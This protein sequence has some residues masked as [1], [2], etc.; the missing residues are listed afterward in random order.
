[1]KKILTICIAASLACA[2]A[3]AQ[4]S[5][6]NSNKLAYGNNIFR[7][8]PIAAMDIGVGFGISYERIF[9][10]GTVGFILPVNWLLENT[11]NWNN[12]M[13]N[14]QYNSYVYFTPGLKV[15]P[16]GQR[17][18]TYGV[19]PSL[20]I[21]YGGGKEWRT[22]NDPWSSSELTDKTIFRLGLLVNNYINFQ[23]TNDFNLG[24]EAGLG[25]RYIDKTT[26][27]GPRIDYTE[28]RGFDVTG[29]FQ[30]TL[31]YRF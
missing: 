24:L 9:G 29:Q 15:Y 3:F 31:G 1:M 16:F 8:A 26:Y 28:N 18:V 17:R 11:E 20:M 30:L 23:L 27:K 14:Q 5:K 4:K 21:G 2:P 7:I 6:N 25:M 19:G 10:E 12:G 22:V 13:N